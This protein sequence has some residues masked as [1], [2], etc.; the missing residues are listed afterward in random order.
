MNLHDMNY[1]AFFSVDKIW[2]IYITSVCKDYR[3]CGINHRLTTRALEE[4]S[5]RGYKLAAS[6][7]MSA[8]TQRNKILRHQIQTV[9]EFPLKD[10]YL[11]YERMS[12]DTKATH[13]KACVLAKTL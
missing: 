8:Y 12:E 4:A 2:Y 5:N 13:T 10:S 11:N 1:D 6:V 3:R 7:S 9:C